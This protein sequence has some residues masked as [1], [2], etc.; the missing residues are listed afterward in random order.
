MADFLGLKYE[1][2]IDDL[3]CVEIS[4]PYSNESLKINS[5]FFQQVN[6]NWLQPATLSKF[7]LEIWNVENSNFLNLDRIPTIPVIYGDAG[8]KFDGC[9]LMLK[10]DIFGSIF[11]MLSRYEE[12]VNPILDA[13]QRFPASSSIACKEGFLER[14]IVD[15][16]VEIL[17]ACLKQLWPTLERK[18]LTSK[19][20]I[21]CD[22]D[23][24]FDGVRHSLFTTLKRSTRL[25]LKDRDLNES[26]CK[27][28]NYLCGLQ[29]K[30]DQYTELVSWIMNSNE[31]AGHKVAF[32][33]ITHNTS[34]LDNHFDFC[35]NEMLTLL[36]K[37]H[38]RGHEIGIHPGYECYDNEKNLSQSI[39]NFRRAMSL[40]G[41]DKLPLGSRMHYL[42]WNILKT[43]Q[44]LDKF[45]VSY[46]STLGFADK[47]GF[48]CG[49]SHEFQMYDLVARK[50]LKLK[51]R[52]LINMESTLISQAYEGLG[53]SEKT[54]ER[55][56]M[57][58]QSCEQYNGTYTLLWHNSHLKT[59]EDKSLYTKLING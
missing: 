31:K 16:Y 4:L 1:L 32:Y 11:F 26:I 21:T 58:M 12:A 14:P 49:T 40:I 7:P 50:P 56:N 57:F 29:G 47:A 10:L 52:P 24:P 30:P 46:D 42:R 2:C 18:P 35:S 38:S 13:H 27:V 55:F 51:Q 25:A 48:R 45:G 20:F 22:V 9:S 5:S 6:S 43:P 28:K 34:R 44:M 37:I 41:V 8:A 54:L 53:Y 17:W 39:E 3:E 33:F 59:E 19:K 36:R 15:E 23:W